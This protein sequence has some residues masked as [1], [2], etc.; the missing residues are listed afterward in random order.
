MEEEVHDSDK[1]VAM[2]VIENEITVMQDLIKK[3]KD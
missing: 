2:S 1:I 3:S